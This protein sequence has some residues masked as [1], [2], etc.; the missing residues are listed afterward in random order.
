MHGRSHCSWRASTSSKARENQ[1]EIADAFGTLGTLALMQGDLAL[2]QTHL[3]KALTIVAAINNRETGG[4]LETSAWDVTLYRG[5]A[6]WRRAGLSES[7]H[8][9]LE[10][11][12]QGVCW[13]LLAPAGR[14]SLSKGNLDQAE[15]WLGRSLAYHAAPDRITFYQV[16][17]LFVA[18]CLAMRSSAMAA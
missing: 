4:W 11:E 1:Y 9:C 5:D 8:L 12:R 15:Q 10:T 18:G 3:R 17:R 7:L 16:W 6:H 14:G 2:A 13:R